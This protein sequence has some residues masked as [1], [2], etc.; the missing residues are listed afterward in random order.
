MKLP[1]SLAIIPISVFIL[2]AAWHFLSSDKS[3]IN[4]APVPFEMKVPKDLAQ[5][6]TVIDQSGNKESNP[7]MQ[8]FLDGA[9]SVVQLSYQ[10]ISGEKTIFMSAYYFVESDFA[11]TVVPNEVPRYGTKLITRNGM[12]LSVSGPQDSIFD[13][14]SQDGKNITKLYGVL[15]NAKS[16]N[17]LAK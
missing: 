12:V 15:N 4:L 3:S 17:Y 14:A 7:K 16:Y 11:K 8:A 1:R 5:R 13:A 10:P 9:I 6:I 2:A